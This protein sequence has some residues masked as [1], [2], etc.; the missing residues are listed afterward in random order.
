MSDIDLAAADLKI[1][2]D[3]N[4]DVALHHQET[5]M[6]ID[7]SILSDQLSPW[8]VADR[9]GNRL[10]RLRQDGM[11]EGPFGPRRFTDQPEFIMMVPLFH[12]QDI[13]FC[14]EVGPDGLK[15]SMLCQAV[16]FYI[17]VAI[18]TVAA[19]I[20]YGKTSFEIA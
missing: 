9:T 16:K 17:V 14:M 19:M 3:G 15:V 8:L 12:R 7:R 11:V 4:A 10:V 20:W 18:A 2:E 6:K 1:V 5:L 13:P